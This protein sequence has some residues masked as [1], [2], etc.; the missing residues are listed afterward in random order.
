MV[1]G[2]KWGQWWEDSGSNN[3]LGTIMRGLNNFF[4]DPGKALGEGISGIINSDPYKALTQQNT[5]QMNPLTDQTYAMLKQLFGSAGAGAEKTMAG[6]SGLNTD[7]SKALGYGKSGLADLRSAIAGMDLTGGQN[8]SQ[9]ALA[10]AKNFDPSAYVRQFLSLEPSLQGLLKTD[11][12]QEWDAA[13]NAAQRASKVAA[14]SM[15]GLGAGGL[16]SGAS[17]LAMSRAAQEQLGG[18]AGGIADRNAAMKQLLYGNTLSGLQQGGLSKQQ[19]VQS[20]YESL[21]SQIAQGNQTRLA[22]G[23]ALADSGMNLGNLSASTQTASNE[24][25]LSK[26]QSMLGYYGG[27]QSAALSGLSSFGEPIYSSQGS[28][29]SNL[30]S[31]LGAIFGK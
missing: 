12:T 31:L 20:A 4:V 25:L 17:A 19:G 15:S 8:A 6:Y 30:T 7:Y 16:N 13:T 18:A 1:T 9:Q 21:A 2:D 3:W 10:S 27:Q 23:Q 28:F 14:S 24:A 26:L 5:Q 29:L 11:N 22:G